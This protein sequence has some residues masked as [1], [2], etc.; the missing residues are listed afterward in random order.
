[1][2]DSHARPGSLPGAPEQRCCKR[3][4][5]DRLLTGWSHSPPQHTQGIKGQ[6]LG[7]LKEG[8]VRGPRVSLQCCW[9]KQG[10][11]NS[12]TGSSFSRVSLGTPD[13]ACRE[14]LERG[15][16]CSA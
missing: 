13:S 2:Q 12:G 9:P 1:M 7:V 5:V 4:A 14:Q 10:E 15:E 16:D 8:A 6:L 11:H 3:R